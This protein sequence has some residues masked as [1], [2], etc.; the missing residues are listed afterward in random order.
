MKVERRFPKDFW[1]FVDKR[2]EARLCAN[3]A[4][5]DVETTGLD[6][7][8]SKLI[9][10]GIADVYRDKIIQYF[11]EPSWKEAVNLL[12]KYKNW[13]AW[14]VYFDKT[15]LEEHAGFPRYNCIIIIWE[16]FV[17]IRPKCWI[18]LQPIDRP[19]LTDFLYPFEVFDPLKNRPTVRIVDWWK[20]YL[21]VR[22]A[23]RSLYRDLILAK[24]YAD[25]VRESWWLCQYM[26]DLYYEK[27]KKFRY[28]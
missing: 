2:L 15:F 25:L 8:M 6:P 21:K 14:N 16:E 18:E 7:K 24:N 10:I 17:E 12:L 3:I 19:R 11:D 4:V 23:D 28:S 26:L 20:E 9:C 22:G 27:R 13:A 5:V 1:L